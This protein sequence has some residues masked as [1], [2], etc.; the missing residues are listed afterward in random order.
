MFDIGFWELVVI[1][2][3]ALL[4]VGPEKL[5]KLA[6]DAGNWIGKI[7]RF[8]NNTR[9]ELERELLFSEQK[10]FE[11]NLTD[12]DNLMKNAPDQDKDFK[13]RMDAESVRNKENKT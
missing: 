13:N 10:K 9:R 1:A 8:I 7:R 11:D 5:P 3:I 2:I 12:L 6:H 4:V